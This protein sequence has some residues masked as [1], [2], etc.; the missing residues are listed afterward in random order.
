[1]NENELHEL[2]ALHALELLA[3]EEAA[4]FELRLVE[5]QD[6]QALVRDLRDSL[7]RVALD[8]EEAEPPADLKRR[9]L[10]TAYAGAAHG[11]HIVRADEGR[12]RQTPYPG[13]QSKLLFRDP[14]TG[15]VTCLLK[16][17][18]GASYPGHRHTTSEQCLVLEGDVRFGE[19]I[20]LRGGD[21]EAAYSGTMHARIYSKEGCVLLILASPH[22]EVFT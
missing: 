15:S 11:M 13:V 10:N 22:D 14:A 12:W 18:P 17:E 7:A 9:A 2:A 21:F 4:E 3:P 19:E 1:M 6:L 5:D 20:C 8:A 16:L